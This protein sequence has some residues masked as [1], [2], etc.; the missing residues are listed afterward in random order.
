MGQTLKA[1]GHA[2]RKQDSNC[3]GQKMILL[4]QLVLVKVGEHAELSFK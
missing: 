4:G 3:I 2:K 1:I